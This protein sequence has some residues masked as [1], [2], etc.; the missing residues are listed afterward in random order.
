MLKRIKQK[1]PKL[2]TRAEFSPSSIN[3][4]TRTLEVIWTT[5]YKGLRRGFFGDYYEELSLDPAHVDM[6][7]LRSGRAKFL[8]S[9][10]MHR[11][12]SVL[13]VIE[14]ADIGNAQVRFSKDEIA[15]RNL[16]KIRD[17][18]LTDVSVGYM[19]EEYTDVSKEG[20]AVPTYRATKWKP[21]EISLV[22]TGFDP[23]ATVRSEEIETNE[24]TI[25][26]R[27]NEQSE[28]EILSRSETNKESLKM[29]EAELKALAEKQAE[30]AKLAERKRV[31]EIR[32]AVKEANLAD[33]LADS[34]VERG[35]SF[36]DAKHQIEDVKAAI[37]EQEKIA[38][39]SANTRVEVGSTGEE[40]RREAAEH[41]LI[42]RVDRKGFDA[43]VMK[44]DF[45]GMSIV[46]LCEELIG[47]RKGLSDVEII[48]RAMSTSDLP[49]I[50]ANV[51]SKSASRQYREAKQ[52]FQ[53]WT[54]TGDLKD[55]NEHSRVKL[56]DFANLEERKEGGEFKYG[57]MGEEN[58][59]AQLVDY[60][61][62]QKLT[63]QMLINDDLR[64][65]EQII[66]KGGVA[67][68]R[69]ESSLVY[70]ELLSNPTLE[71]TVALFHAD[72][73]NLGSAATITNGISDGFQKMR[74]Q[75][76]V[77]GLD[78]LELSPAFLLCGPAKE[79]EA[80]QVLATI[81][82]TQTSNVNPYSQSVQLIVENRITTT[83]WFLSADPS[84]VDTITL[85][86]LTGQ[87]EP[88]ISTRE[89]WN[90]SS[91]EFKVEHTVDASAMD[92]RG[93]YYNP[94]A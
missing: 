90:D 83:K 45:V 54:S 92:F 76:S 11:N 58:E 8:D 65:L 55:Y 13:G 31:Q 89:N 64:M 87:E 88:I 85:F 20:D 30:E 39:I 47:G 23:G 34:Y 10:D 61:K 36:E 56:G 66:S 48:K 44:K 68:R 2:Q 50:L 27:S 28:A 79:K 32:K 40:K 62:I 5:G 80:R 42:Y 18:I 73:G 46:R 60:G 26:T 52:T 7:H 17:G 82:A 37:K 53:P 25:V 35:L 16:Q 59:T 43:K 6:S 57:S 63:K 1:I 49:L 72:H 70:T 33:T 22:P 75:T 69:K 71:D 81:A 94:G 78:N 29:T 67:A 15:E 51:A 74:E 24:V 3:L 93:L 86:K 41:S 84:T 14:K 38:A 12:D 77:D 19:V 21:I 9:H 4:E 91:I